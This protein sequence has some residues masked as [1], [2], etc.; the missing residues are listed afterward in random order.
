MCGGHHVATGDGQLHQLGA[1]ILGLET[2]AVRGDD[3]NLLVR[4]RV[5][6]I[7]K[8]LLSTQFL[9][10]CGWETLFP[11]DCA[12]ADLVMKTSGTRITLVK[13]RCAW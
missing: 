2:G 6:D 4:F 1:R 11:A 5:T 7:G 13:A 9:S 10:R 12:D 3:V 8:A